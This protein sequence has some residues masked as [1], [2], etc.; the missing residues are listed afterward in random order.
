MKGILF[1]I[2]SCWIAGGVSGQSWNKLEAVRVFNHRLAE[3]ALQTQSIECDFIQ[4]KYLDVF[5]EKVISKGKFY[6]R[7][8]NKISLS[9]TQPLDYL[10]TINGRQLKLVADGKTNIVDL[11]TNKMMNSMNKLLAACMTGNLGLLEEGYRLEYLEDQSNYLV[12]ITPQDQSVKAYLA[13]MSVFFDKKDMAVIKLRLAENAADYT[14]YR[15][16]NR[17]FNTLKDD[18]KFTIR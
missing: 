1:F 17:E 15:F 7:K 14:E 13:E 10:I 16:L 8:E 9:Y 2:V 3:T 12:R 5:A 11:G 6:F 18:E 4:E